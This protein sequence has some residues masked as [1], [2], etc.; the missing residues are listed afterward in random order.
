MAGKKINYQKVLEKEIA[1]VKNLD[2][3]PSLLMHTC[4]APCSSYVIE[5]LMEYFEITL[6]FYNPNIYP[7]SEYNRRLT[8]LELFLR[9]FDKEKKVKLI[10]DEYSHLEFAQCSIGLEDEKEGGERCFRCYDLRMS[11]TAARAEEMGYDYFSTT[12]S[13]SPHKN[14]EKINDLGRELSAIHDVKFLYADFKKNGGFKR[15]LE[16]SEEYQLY[17]QDYCGCE[18]SMKE[19]PPLIK[20][21]DNA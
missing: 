10:H 7:E 12:L 5:F 1:E 3:K 16:I 11:M 15:S 14:A 20:P 13:I 21:E 17:R 9:S 4:C 2:K 19:P 6:Y 18:Y 8:E